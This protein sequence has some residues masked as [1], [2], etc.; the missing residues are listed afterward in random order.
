MLIIRLDENLMECECSLAR[1]I[2]ELTTSGVQA[3]PVSTGTFET[4]PAIRFVQRQ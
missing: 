1:Q 2:A 3:P 4:D